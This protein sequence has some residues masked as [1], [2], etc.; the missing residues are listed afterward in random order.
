MQI[1]K[2]QY[3]K[4]PKH[5]QQHFSYGCHHPTVK[6]IQLLAYLITLG[7]RPGD[8]I[9]DPFAGSFTTG[10]AAKLL[11]RKYICIEKEAEYFEI[12]TARLE[13]TQEALL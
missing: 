12:G 5:L 11:G 7:S 4:L 9:L 13:A 8:T 3:A 1:T 10:C 2:E 6:P